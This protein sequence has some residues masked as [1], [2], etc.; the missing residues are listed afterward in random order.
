MLVQ[1]LRRW[2]DIETALGDC[3]VFAGNAHYYAGDAFHL[4]SPENPLLK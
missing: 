2:T 1:R 3:P 4:L